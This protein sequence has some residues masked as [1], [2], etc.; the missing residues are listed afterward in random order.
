MVFTC[1]GL[2]ALLWA[3]A[4]AYEL[5]QLRSEQASYWSGLLVNVGTTLLLATVLVRFERV[6]VR[7]VRVENGEAIVQAADAAAEHCHPYR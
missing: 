2:A 4:I 6:L 7:R 3:W 1:A 5:T